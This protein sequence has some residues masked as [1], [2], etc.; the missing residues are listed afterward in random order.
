[1]VISTPI[2][3]YAMNNWLKDFAYHIDIQWWVFVLTGLLAILIAL[4]TVSY[5]SIRAALMNP[6]KSLRSE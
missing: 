5:Q 2:A 4:L 6:V 3:W 1:I